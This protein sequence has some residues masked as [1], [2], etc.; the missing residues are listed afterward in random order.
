MTTHLEKYEH[1]QG[2][3]FVWFCSNRSVER[4]EETNSSGSVVALHSTSNVQP[5]CLTGPKIISLS[6]WGPYIEWLTFI[7]AKTEFSYW[8]NSN[9]NG[10]TTTVWYCA[11]NHSSKL[12][13][14]G[15]F[16]ANGTIRV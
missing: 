7:L 6:S 3:A 12:D 15:K 8:K 16:C 4:F 1:A 14:I 9:A 2:E 10:M 13:A 5:K 11:F